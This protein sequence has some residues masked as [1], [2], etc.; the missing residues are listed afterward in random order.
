MVKQSEKK[1]FERQYPQTDIAIM[2]IRT[3]QKTKKSFDDIRHFYGY[4]QGAFLTKLMEY[5]TDE[6]LRAGYIPQKEDV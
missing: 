3:T 6:A 5:A 4:T 1:Y 2:T